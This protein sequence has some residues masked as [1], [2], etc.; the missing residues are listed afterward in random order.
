[1]LAMSFV[2]VTQTDAKRHA[3]GRQ[4]RS[5]LD[6]LAFSTAETTMRCFCSISPQP[7]ARTSSQY[8]NNIML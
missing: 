3:T 4:P 6:K 7:E 8:E 1:M 2:D 5:D